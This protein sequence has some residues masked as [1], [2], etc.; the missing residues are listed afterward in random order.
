MMATF[1]S[2]ASTASAVTGLVWFI[3]YI[4]YSFSYQTY[5]DMTLGTKL[6]WCLVSNTAMGFGLQLILGHEGNGEGL[7]WSN[8]F[9]PINIDDDLTVGAVILMMLTSAVIYMLIA[10]YVE[11]IF[12]GDYGV[13]KK[14]YFPF[15]KEFWCGTPVNAD[16][17]EYY[18]Y[19]RSNPEAFEAEPEGKHIGVQ[20]KNLQ[21]TF[22]NKQVVKGINLNM[23]E[24]EITVLLGHNGAGKTTTISMLTGMFPPTAGTALINGSDIRTNTEGARMSLGICPQ[25]NVLFDEMNVDDHI[26]FFSRLKGLKGKAIDNEVSKYLKM[27]E[28]EDKAKVASAKLSG[29]MK[30]KLS[31]CCA[32]CGDTKVVLCDEPSSGMDPSARRQLWDLLQA[33]KAGR[34]LLLTTHF[35]DEADVLG[36]RIAIMCD[37]QLKCHGT[38]FFLK[39]KFGSGYRLVRLHTL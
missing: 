35:M 12:P 7:R 39:K 32:L 4:P 34:T 15:T 28:L 20:V 9:E 36:D 11:Q 37:G 14:W 8:M 13:P 23:Y 24:N 25:H 19:E 3:A 1:F 16:D 29:G 22:G 33:E 5:D 31:L 30:R 21:K 26:V 38:S 18:K 17:V 2:K 6:G 10:L 27:I